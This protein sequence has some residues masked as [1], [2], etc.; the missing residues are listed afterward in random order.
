MAIQARLDLLPEEATA[1]KDFLRIAVNGLP[2]TATDHL[3]RGLTYVADK[4]GHELARAAPSK[5]AAP[6]PKRRGGRL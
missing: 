4:L 6:L 3:R 5:L 1:I 2:Q